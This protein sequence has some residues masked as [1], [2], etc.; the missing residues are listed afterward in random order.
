MNDCQSRNEHQRCNWSFRVGAV[1]WRHTCILVFGNYGDARKDVRSSLAT[2][3]RHLPT[4]KIS[5]VDYQATNLEAY[6]HA[7]S[8]LSTRIQVYAQWVLAR[9]FTELLA[10]NPKSW[11]ALEI[12]DVQVNRL[13]V[14]QPCMPCRTSLLRKRRMPCFLLML[15]TPSGMSIAR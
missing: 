13:I 8:S 5:L 11:K 14:S 4:K 12:C 6:R 7:V 10:S 2:R 15:P 9:S 3:S 1:G